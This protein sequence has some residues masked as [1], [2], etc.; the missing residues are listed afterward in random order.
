M[1]RCNSC[2]SDKN[3]SDFGK[4]KASIDGLAAKCMQC[5]SEYDKARNSRIDRV[6]ARKAYS[7]TMAGI[8]AGNK[9]KKKW[10]ENNPQKLAERQKKW[11]EE[12]PNKYKAHGKVA[13][14]VRKGNLTPKPCEKCGEEESVA[15]HDDYSKPLDVTWLCDFHHKQWHKKYGAGKNG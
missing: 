11:R 1:K 14:E 10:A 5:Q 13:Y 6:E 15:H 3:E 7:L 9:A 4:R 12:N 2:D 8:Y